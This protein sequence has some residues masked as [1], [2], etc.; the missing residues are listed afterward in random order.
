LRIDIPEIFPLFDF[1]SEITL[2]PSDAAQQHRE[3]IDR[4]G[5]SGFQGESF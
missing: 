5:I 4:L 2:L 3:T 1:Q